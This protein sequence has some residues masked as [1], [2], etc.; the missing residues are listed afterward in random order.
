MH[1]R[2]KKMELRGS[3]VGNEKEEKSL[4]IE[5]IFILLIPNKD[6]EKED[7]D[8]MEKFSVFMSSEENSDYIINIINQ[9]SKLKDYRAYDLTEYFDK[10]KSINLSELSERNRI[11]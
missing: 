4:P 5:E 6:K 7:K 2:K 8:I 9:I 11:V 3:E 1:I 10:I